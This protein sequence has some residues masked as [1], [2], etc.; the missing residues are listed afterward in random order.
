MEEEEGNGL[1][2]QVLEVVILSIGYDGQFQL[3]KLNIE[4]HLRSEI[5]GHSAFGFLAFQH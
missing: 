5:K 3:L 4:V 2:K 1:F